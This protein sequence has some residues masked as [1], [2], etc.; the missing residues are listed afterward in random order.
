M[1]LLLLWLVREPPRRVAPEDAHRS[2]S[3]SET[4]GFLWTHRDSL[5]ALFAGL[6]LLGV[7]S[8]ATMTWYP[9]LFV[10]NFGEPVQNVGL[11]FGPIYVVASMTGNIAG[12]WCA[13]RLADR[14]HRD[15]Y[16]LW[17]LSR[18]LPWP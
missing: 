16:V 4:M 1:V 7:V 11:T 14:G 3:F 9:T 15:P 8:Y 18:R 6:S 17:A 2:A 12:A 5:G 10:R 13:V